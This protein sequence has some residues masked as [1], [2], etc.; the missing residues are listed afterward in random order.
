MTTVKRVSSTPSPIA[1]VAAGCK[2]IH[3]LLVSL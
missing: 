2:A 1:I 3:G